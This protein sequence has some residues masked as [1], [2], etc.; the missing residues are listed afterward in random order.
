MFACLFWV[1]EGEISMLFTSNE[2]TI[3]KVCQKNGYNSQIPTHSNSNIINR[4]SINSFTSQETFL[5]LR[6]VLS[7]VKKP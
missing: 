6:K 1:R 3:I 4:K 7:A 2:R 5:L